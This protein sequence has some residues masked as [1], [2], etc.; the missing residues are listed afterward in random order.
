MSHDSKNF[1]DNKN[2]GAFSKSLRE[3]E[4]KIWLLRRSFQEKFVDVN[5]EK[6]D[7]CIDMSIILTIEGN[8]SGKLR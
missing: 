6:V 7:N 3:F 5:F 1:S 2:I 8:P 4:L